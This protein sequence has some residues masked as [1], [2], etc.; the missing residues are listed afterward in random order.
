[1]RE[2]GW[3]NLGV[4]VQAQRVAAGTRER[5]G[6]ALASLQPT[7]SVRFADGKEQGLPNPCNPSRSSCTHFC[8]TESFL[9]SFR[10]AQN[11]R[12]HRLSPT[13]ETILHSGRVELVSMCWSSWSQSGSLG[14]RTA[15]SKGRRVIMKGLLAET[16]IKDK[17]CSSP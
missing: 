17:P 15:H 13:R 4:Q 3:L 12:R 8:R 16:G 1:M 9:Q 14:N 6:R 2:K 11:K 5:A 10:V 7:E